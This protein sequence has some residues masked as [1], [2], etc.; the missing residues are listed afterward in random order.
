LEALEDRQLLAVQMNVGP[1]ISVGNI[2][3]DQVEG[4]IAV[5]PT[6]TNNIFVKS[7]GLTVGRYSMDG[8]A[9]WLS[10]GAIPGGSCCDD[11]AVFDQY[12]N[13]F[14]SYIANAGGDRLAMSI[15]GG[16]TWTQ[17]LTSGIGGDYP[18]VD[19]GPDGTGFSSVWAYGDNGATISARGAQVT[20]LGVVGA[21]TAAQTATVGQFGDIAVGRDGRV[22]VTGT[23]CSGSQNGPCPVK[24]ATDFNGL[25]A[26]G[27]SAPVTVVT[28]NVGTFTPIPAEDNRT[29]HAHPNLAY[30][31]NSD[32]LYI[33]YADR[34][35]TAS[36]DT[37][38]YMQLS[39][40]GSAWAPRIK[41]ND[42]GATGKSQFYSDIDVDPVSNWVAATWYD[43]R[44]SPT[45]VAA[46]IFGTV[47][48]KRG[49]SWEPNVQ[50]ATGLS[51]ANQASSFEFG[52]FDTM[53]FENKAFYRVWADNASPSSITPTNTDAPGDQDYAFAK[54]DVIFTPDPI[55]GGGFGVHGV[56]STDLRIGIK[57]TPGPDTNLPIVTASEPLGTRGTP[58]VETSAAQPQTQ[59]RPTATLRP[60]AN[61]LIHSV[62][63]EDWALGL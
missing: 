42:D 26:G 49:R 39:D 4:T 48:V 60:M 38:I 9:T 15:N 30:A 46:Q 13:L 20:G 8:G 45:N 58:A 61:A 44:N 54:V 55:P 12:G 22:T 31:L 52:D 51:N 2:G 24:V 23:H 25:A 37:D 34:P 40:N 43:C 27:F 10:S 41:L 63:A 11:K 14:M 35:N 36:A 17:L 19:V 1:N 50:I 62:F 16:A 53:T 47:T 33:T 59:P 29:I 18:G 7:I 21:F 3:S 28:S 57:P 6:N 56:D 5:N 32:R